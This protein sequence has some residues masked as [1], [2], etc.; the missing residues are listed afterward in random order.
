MENLDLKDRKILYQLDLNCR[1]SNAQIG[2]KVG[3]SRKVVEYR[4]KRMEE[5]GI[6]KNYWTAIN[7]FRLGYEV[8]RIY[9]NY[10]NITPKIENEIIDYFTNCK[11]IWAVIS[12]KG[13]IDLTVILWMKNNYE[14]F[15]FWNKTQEQYE[16]YMSQVN[17]NNYIKTV[18]FEK[19]YLINDKDDKSNRKLYELDC[20][21]EDIKI[22][23]LDYKI[24]NELAL[25][26][27]M[28]LIE[29][30]EKFDSSSQTIKYRINNLKKLKIILAFRIHLDYE[31]INLKHFK[32]DIFLKKKKYKKVINDYLISKPYTQCLNTAVGWADLEPEIV[33]KNF[34]V[35][36][37]IFEKIQQ[38]YPG[39]IKKYNYWIGE[40]YHKE[41][42]LPEMEFK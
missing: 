13:V 34:D 38:K 21:A 31:K 18:D 35:L 6:I 1:Q 22:D 25:N 42:W 4:I 32:V 14:F 7:A 26:G 16:S 27:R 30:S 12:S 33:V 2:K 15:K 41:R 17:I 29:L 19:T 24:L 23:E 3:L 11:N 40:T 10:Q 9:I 20:S 28:P 8:F 37:K 39:Y 36:D 5:E